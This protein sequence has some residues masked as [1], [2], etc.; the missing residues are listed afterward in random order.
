MPEINWTEAIGSLAAVLSTA[1]FLPQTVRLLV[2]RETAAIS[3]TMYIIFASGV[4]LW[5]VYGVA[6]ESW[7]IIIGNGI[8]L[9]FALAIIGAKL[10]YG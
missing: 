10:R 9:A 4:T 7:P 2:R 1:A 5:L 6:H 8:T 3:L